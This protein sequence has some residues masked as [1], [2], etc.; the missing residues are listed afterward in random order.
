M[1]RPSA[2]PSV[3]VVLVIS[4]ERANMELISQLIARRD[5]LKLLTA[6]NCTDGIKL[7]GACQPEVV[8]MD[9]QLSDISAREAL[10]RLHQNPETSHIPVVA[11]SSDAHKIQIDAGLQAGFFRYLTKPFKLTD[12]LDAID[13]SL[14]Y[15]REP[16]NSTAASNPGDGARTNEAI[17]MV[18]AVMTLDFE[19]PA[20]GQLEKLV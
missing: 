2:P 4:S 10:K 17:S 9:T 7:A 20:A 13:D 19:C 12:L 11:V 8:V 14:G 6:N 18:P 15:T 5:D 16:M 1:S 3:L